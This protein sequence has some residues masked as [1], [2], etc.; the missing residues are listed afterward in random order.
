MNSGIRRAGLVVPTHTE[1][2]RRYREQKCGEYLYRET[3]CS[4]KSTEKRFPSLLMGLGKDFIHG[5]EG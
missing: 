2:K 4:S 5:L 3:F 1:Y